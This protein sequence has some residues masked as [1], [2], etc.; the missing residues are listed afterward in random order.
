[1][2]QNC[3]LHRHEKYT[4]RLPLTQQPAVLMPKRRQLTAE[5][6]KDDLR[7]AHDRALEVISS[8]AELPVDGILPR[9]EFDWI[10]TFIDENPPEVHTYRET[11]PGYRRTTARAITQRRTRARHRR[12]QEPP[13]SRHPLLPGWSVAR[14]P[15]AVHPVQSQGHRP[16]HAQAHLH[17]QPLRMKY[18]FSTMWF[19]SFVV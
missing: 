13:G 19:T 7:N 3:E 2:R 8:D 10:K 11:F 14:K 5:T 6:P 15:R 1:M 12:V 18:K 9:D 17:E 16:V 4:K